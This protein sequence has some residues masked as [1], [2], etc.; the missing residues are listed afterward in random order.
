MQSSP[1]DYAVLHEVLFFAGEFRSRSKGRQPQHRERR[2]TQLQVGL[3]VREQRLVRGMSQKQLAMA[4]N[5]KVG[6]VA[7][8]ELGN[9]QPPRE[10]LRKIEGILMG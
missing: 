6:Y 3:A 2:D 10:L 4:V 5:V 8:I 9:V 1:L 7:D